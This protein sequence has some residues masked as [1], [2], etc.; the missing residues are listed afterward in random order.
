[1]GK[2]QRYYVVATAKTCEGTV[3][4]VIN[5]RGKMMMYPPLSPD[6]GYDSSEQA[7]ASSLKAERRE[8]R[9]NKSWWRNFLFGPDHVTYSVESFMS[10]DSSHAPRV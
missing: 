2:K 5:P 8:L 3:K 10:H 1:M 4:Y 7:T 9:K 6:D